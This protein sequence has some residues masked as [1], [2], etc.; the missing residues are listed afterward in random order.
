MQ[1]LFLLII[2]CAQGFADPTQK[3]DSLNSI[4]L[5][6]IKS[7]DFETARS[8]LIQAQNLAEEKNYTIGISDALN[9]QGLL[10][11]KQGDLSNAEHAY[12]Q[13]LAL[14]IQTPYA[15]KKAIRLKNLGILKKD[16]GFFAESKGYLE[17]ALTLFLEEKDQSQIASTY[18]S[19]G[20]LWD[21]LGQ[22]QQAIGYQ[23]KAIQ[24]FST[25]SDSARLAYAYNNLAGS[26]VKVNEYESALA[27]YYRSLALKN[28]LNNLYSSASTLNNI[29]EV[30]HAQSNISEAYQ[31]YLASFKLKERFGNIKGQAYTANNLAKLFIE[32]GAYDSA[33]HYLRLSRKLSIDQNLR[34]ILRE[35]FRLSSALFESI[36]DNQ[37]SLDFHKRYSQ[38]NDSLF[39]VEKVAVL[40]HEMESKNDQLKRFES[41]IEQRNSYIGWLMFIS[42]GS[43]TFIAFYFLRKS[44]SQGS[45][46]TLNTQHG[47]MEKLAFKDNTGKVFL[48]TPSSIQ[49]VEATDR[50]CKIF[51]TEEQNPIRYSNSLSALEKIMGENE[52]FIR[53]SSKSKYLINI[54]QLFRIDKESLIFSRSPGSE[55]P[56]AVA[57]TKNQIRQ[58]KNK[59]PILK[60]N[61]KD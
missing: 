39:K 4:A 56:R 52:R 54:D 17:K 26:Y 7:S 10:N 11:A 42:I 28:A 20:L 58:L 30:Y 8:V 14:I 13:S 50:L 22:T 15:D 49:Y 60:A 57:I 33:F 16:Q 41:S 12:K 61:Q 48:L 27:F 6:L 37:K 25:I 40:N 24:V 18:L 34:A 55:E 3:V 53:L 44:R 36:G 19:L 5:Q 29:G 38:L 43:L 45:A 35:N 21:E 59:L 31:Y 2:S 51:S 46:S 1:F 47:L 32:N 9:N 23:Q